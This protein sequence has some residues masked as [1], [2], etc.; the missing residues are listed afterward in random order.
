M[1]VFPLIDEDLRH[2]A[3]EPPVPNG[4]QFDVEEHSQWVEPVRKAGA[5]CRSK[6]EALDKIIKGWPAAD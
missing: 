4:L 1:L 3:A 5:D 2:C 6:L